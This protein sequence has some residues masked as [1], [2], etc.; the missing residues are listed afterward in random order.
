MANAGGFLG[1]VN[2]S[3]CLVLPR[4]L[5]NEAGGV[6][7]RFDIAGGGLVNLDLFSRLVAL[8]DSQLVVL[9][10][11]GSF[12]QVHGGAATKPGVDHTPWHE[13]Y[14]A[15]RG[16]PYTPPTVEPVYYGALTEPARR[17]LTGPPD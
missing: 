13:Q 1:P 12:H 6:D 14:H 17:W 3:C 5:W 8:P 16:G 2:E 10:G 9:L 4:S 15:L 11:E 7:E